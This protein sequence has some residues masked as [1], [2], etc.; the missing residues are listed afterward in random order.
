M[1]L[2]TELVGVESFSQSDGEP[3]R[4]RSSCRAGTDVAVIP[5]GKAWQMTLERRG[6]RQSGGGD[7][8]GRKRGRTSGSQPLVCSL[9]GNY[10]RYFP[11]VSE[12]PLHPAILIMFLVVPCMALY[13]WDSK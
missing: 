12:I 9:E 8:G 7:K 6:T 3:E 10:F 2:K 13:F 1:T 4:S 5:K 11:L